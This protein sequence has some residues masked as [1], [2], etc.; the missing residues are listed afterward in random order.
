MGAGESSR[1]SDLDLAVEAR[2]CGRIRGG[3]LNS[4]TRSKV[5]VALDIGAKARLG[6]VRVLWSW[7]RNGRE[8]GWRLGWVRVSEEMEREESEQ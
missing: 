5:E 7:A 6:S 8:K 4:W 1:R 2:I 3:I